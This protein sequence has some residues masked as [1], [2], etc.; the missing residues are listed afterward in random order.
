MGLFLFYMGRS[1]M[2]PRGSVADVYLIYQPDVHD[3]HELAWDDFTEDL[4][5]VIQGRYK[6][7]SVPN[8]ERWVDCECRVI[9]ENRHGFV[10]V[11]EYYGLVAV[12]LVPFDEY[13]N[14]HPEMSKAW[15][16]NLVA[17]FQ[18]LIHKSFPD[19]SVLK[20]GTFSNGEAAFRKVNTV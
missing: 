9:L 14:R 1:V 2:I 7:F 4:A 13:P 19:G 10:T 20:I 18:E 12:S 15:C 16:E 8:Q 5:Q 6:S 17:G 3:D 11:S